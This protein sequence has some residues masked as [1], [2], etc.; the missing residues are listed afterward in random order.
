[1]RMTG[2]TR[3][4]SPAAE[5]NA[6]SILHVLRTYLPPAGLVLEIASGSGQHAA[7]FAAALPA[8][9]FQPS[10]IEAQNRASIAAW[11]AEFGN[12]RPAI[13]LDASTPDWPLQRADAVLCINMSHISPWAA[14]QGLIAG[15]ARLLPPH[16]LLALYGPYRQAGKDLEPSNEVFDADLRRRHPAWGLRETGAVTDLAQKAGFGA[17][18]IVSMPANNLMIL[19]RAIGSPP[20]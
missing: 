1:M 5:R 17:P 12:V 2:D 20:A 16:G 10:D 13:M 6:A 11:T 19:Y 15:A 8:L 7:Y 9:Q 18:E 14:T 4:F 3:L